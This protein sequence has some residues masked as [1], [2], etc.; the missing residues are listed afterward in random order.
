MIP[1]F[2]ILPRVYLAAWLSFWLGED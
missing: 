2:I 1:A